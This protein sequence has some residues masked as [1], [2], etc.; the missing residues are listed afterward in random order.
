MITVHL[1]TDE[2]PAVIDAIGELLSIPT[3]S[4]P[5]ATVAAAESYIADSKRA[6]ELAF[7]LLSALS[8][9]TCEQEDRHDA[10]RELR[11]DARDATADARGWLDRR[12][13]EGWK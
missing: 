7:P 12:T 1:P 4:G 5:M 3:P 13:S 11:D 10:K 6:R 8:G 2:R 9:I